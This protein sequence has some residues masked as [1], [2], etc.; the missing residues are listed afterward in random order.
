MTTRLVCCLTLTRNDA[1]F[2]C[3]CSVLREC[4]RA[5]AVR[6]LCVCGDDSQRWRRSHERVARL[7]FVTDL[8]QHYCAF[9]SEGLVS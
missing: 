2:L 3:D 7:P 6:F 4:V 1:T 5:T 9:S 8:L